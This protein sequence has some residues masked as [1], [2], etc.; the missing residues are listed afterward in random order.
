MLSLP[1]SVRVYV[2]AGPVDMR[3]GHHGLAAVVQNSLQLDPL[4]GHLVLFTN[5]RGNRMKLLWFDRSGYAMLF[6]RL[7]RGT[8][9]LPRVPDGA[10]RVQVDLATLAMILEG[11]DLHR[12]VRR[13][14]YRHP[15]RDAAQKPDGQIVFEI[16]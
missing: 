9:Q 14:R 13:P 11:I 12:A 2:A 3:M 15:D 10:A 4:A 16:S 6:K 8:F 7:E 5:R 1:A